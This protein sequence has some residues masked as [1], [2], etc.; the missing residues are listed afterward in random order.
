M[1]RAYITLF[2]IIFIAGCFPLYSSQ[3]EELDKPPEGAHEGQMLVG[4]FFSIG[5]PYGDAI[6]GRR[7]S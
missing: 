3:F 4:G 1:K 2:L 6:A 7:I 5:M